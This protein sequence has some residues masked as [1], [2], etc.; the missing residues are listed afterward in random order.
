MSIDYES[1]L[2]YGAR[3]SEIVHALDDKEIDELNEELDYCE[4]DYASPYYNA[5]RDHWII[6]YELSDGFSYVDK[7]G[8]LSE[9]EDAERKFK[10]RFGFVGCV[11]STLDVY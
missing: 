10:E 11:Y 9:L 2:I 6:G 1:K 7:H 5:P 8:F 4:I 3:Y